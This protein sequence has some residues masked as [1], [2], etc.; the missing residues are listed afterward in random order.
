MSTSIIP[1]FDP[2]PEHL[3]VFARLIAGAAQDQVMRA[4]DTVVHY[5][6][7][8]HGTAASVITRLVNSGYVAG[9]YYGGDHYLAHPDHERV[10]PL[11]DLEHSFALFV[12]AR[13]SALGERSAAI[14]ALRGL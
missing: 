11:S 14:Q 1:T 7:G 9:Q 5:D 13:G 2:A 12:L 10:V 8:H 3:M 6:P 4:L